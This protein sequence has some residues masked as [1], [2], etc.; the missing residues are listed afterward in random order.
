MSRYGYGGGDHRQ[1]SGDYRQGGYNSGYRNGG[2]GYANYGKI[3]EDDVPES[4]HSIFIRGL[5]SSLTYDE[6][7][8]F[9]EDNIGPCSFDFQKI[10]YERQSLFVAMRFDSKDHA[11]DAYDKYR[12][13]DILGC[14]CEVTWF[15]DIRRYISYQQQN[16]MSESHRGVIRR[17]NFGR[18]QMGRYNHNNRQDYRKRRYSDDR[19][20]RSRS[21]SDSG[22]SRSRSRRSSRSR[23]SRSRSRSEGER[24][25]SKESERRPR[26]D[27]KDDKRRKKDKKIKKSKKDR[28]SRRS[29]SA[30]SRSDGERSRSNSREGR[31][32]PD[33][34]KKKS[35]RAGSASSTGSPL[36]MTPP[37]VAPIIGP[38]IPSAT[39]PPVPSTAAVEK[40]VPLSD[41][42]VVDIS[43]EEN[44]FYNIKER[45]SRKKKRSKK[46]DERELDS[47]KDGKITITIAN[48]ATVPVENTSFKMQL[49]SDEPPRKIIRGPMTPPP[50]SEDDAMEVEEEVPLRKENIVAD[51]K[52]KGGWR[53]VG[54]KSADGAAEGQ[55]A[56]PP[57]PAL[58]QP[59][60]AKTNGTP[61]KHIN[62]F[63]MVPRSV[64]GPTPPS[65]GTPNPP[66]PK[67][68]PMGA[69]SSLPPP[70]GRPSLGGLQSKYPE[71]AKVI[72]E[73][74]GTQD[75]LVNSIKPNAFR[76]SDLSSGE[77]MME[78]M[79]EREKQINELDASQKSKFG[80][81][82]KQ[83][84][85][86]YKGD[87]G[88]ITT[89]IK[90]VVAKDPSLEDQIKPALLSVLE[91]LEKQIYKKVDD[92]LAC[93]L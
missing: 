51:P 22:R 79:E 74:K 43:D 58:V 66:P 31:D 23:S 85:N 60:L 11:K 41:V 67:R 16:G 37:P 18:G 1:G 7:K 53:S 3:N 61:D 46:L 15:R 49:D 8:N 86:S 27:S 34:R 12:D 5:P 72:K 91:D 38:I 45:K 21:D 76:L 50:L 14:R 40:P 78:K 92:F 77:S 59:T 19:R 35:R 57:A 10:N 24:S 9:F 26:S 44:D 80:L 83:I 25:T 55:T 73:I 13:S 71:M 82:M 84:T 39:S 65:G 93:G 68:P 2:G 6:I 28:H 42:E 69:P 47:G 52:E 32:R 87:A 36:R 48:K 20:S 30:S 56:T 81:K 63:D 89:V 64:A 54:D 62:G 17:G 90:S 4:Q 75:V 70:P 33:S 29:G 88:T